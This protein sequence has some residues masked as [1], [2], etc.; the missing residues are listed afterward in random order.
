[1]ALKLARQ[2]PTWSLRRLANEANTTPENVLVHTGSVFRRDERGRYHANDRDRLFREMQLPSARGLITVGVTDS[3]TASTIG[4]YFS[5]IGRFKRSGDIRELR[6]FRGKSITVGKV[7]Y[8]L[9]TDPVV[10]RRLLDA[11][12]LSTD[13]IYRESV[14]W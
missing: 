8:R 2:H 6:P 10:L 9:L 13:S 11:D 12:E 4:K 3:R 7:R 1:L 14:S 5:A